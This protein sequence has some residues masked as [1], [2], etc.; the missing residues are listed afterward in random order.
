[1]KFETKHIANMYIEPTSGLAVGIMSV[2]KV[3]GEENAAQTDCKRENFVLKRD[4]AL[5]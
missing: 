3:D 1:M 5:K 2:V 4:F